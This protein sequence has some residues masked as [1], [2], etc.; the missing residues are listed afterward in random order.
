MAI[1]DINQR[2][3]V[4]RALAIVAPLYDALNDPR[5]KNTAALVTRATTDDWIDCGSDGQCLTRDQIISFWQTFGY[6][7]PNLKWDLKEVLVTGDRVIVRSEASGTPATAFLAFPIPAGASRVCWLSTST[8]SNA[9]K[10]RSP[11]TLKTGLEQ[12]SS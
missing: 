1:L 4:E 2:D 6:S 11:S 9:E 10:S 8:Q 3:S 12:F 5:T 7:V